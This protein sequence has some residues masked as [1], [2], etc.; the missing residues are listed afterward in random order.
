MGPLLPP[1]G[2][3]DKA[4]YSRK[5]FG[6]VVRRKVDFQGACQA[7]SS[8]SWKGRYKH[9]SAHVE[10]KGGGCESKRKLLANIAMSQV[11]RKTG[12][13]IRM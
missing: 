4:P 3:A 12:A 13:L 2:G 8:Q 5:V 9:K 1:K 6:P 10:S 11:Y 7:D